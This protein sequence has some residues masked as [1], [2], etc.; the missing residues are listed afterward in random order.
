MPQVC[1]ELFTDRTG[2]CLID[3]QEKLAAAMPEKVLKGTLR[4]WLNL[5]E[6]ARVLDLPVVVSEQYPTGLGRTL[7][8]VAE[9]VLRLPRERVFFFEKVQFSCAR[10]GPFD[11]WVKQS[12]RTQWVLAGMETHI[13]VFQTARTLRSQ[14]YDVHVPRDAAV[15]RTMANWEVGLQ[16]MQR[17]DAVV[18]ST[19]VVIFDLLKQAG[20]D[21]FK[22]L[23]RIVR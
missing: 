16:L 11:A 9:A 20:T 14:G 18:T 2:V 8:V 12:G 6:T 23:S 4:N 19:E 1:C 13:C 15:S 17:S 21:A 7:P 10:L 5:I 3:I 22:M